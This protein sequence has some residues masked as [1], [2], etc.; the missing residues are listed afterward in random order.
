MQR[1]KMSESREGGSN[2][3]N[4]SPEYLA[5]KAAELGKVKPAAKTKPAADKPNTRRFK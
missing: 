3:L 1:T 2:T 5:E 4:R